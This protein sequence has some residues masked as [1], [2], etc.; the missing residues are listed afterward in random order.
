MNKADIKILLFIGFSIENMQYKF[1][2]LIVLNQ[3]HTHKIGEH[4]LAFMAALAY[5]TILEIFHKA[6]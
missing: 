6:F 5:H 4:A 3:N 1:Q 2:I